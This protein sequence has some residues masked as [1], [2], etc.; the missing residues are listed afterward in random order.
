MREAAI[1]LLFDRIPYGAA[2]PDFAGSGPPLSPRTFMAWCPRLESL[3]F[4]FYTDWHSSVYGRLLFPTAAFRLGSPSS[5][6]EMVPGIVHPDGSNLFLHQP[7]WSTIRQ[8]FWDTLV[9]VH[10]RISLRVRSLYVSLLDVRDEICRRL[11]LSAA[12]FDDFLAL[13]LQELPDQELPWSVSIETDIREEQRSGYGLLRRPIYIQG[14]PHT[15]IAVA[16]LPELE[17]S[18]L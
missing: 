11:R 4:I 13:A 9:A 17:R 6:F 14:V 2:Q 3:E 7:E 12:R 10:R 8:L 15:L 16:R 5:Q 18:P 1:R